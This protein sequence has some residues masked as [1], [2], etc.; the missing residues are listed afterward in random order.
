[1]SKKSKVFL[2]GWEAAKAH[3][4][5]DVCPYHP[6]DYNYREWKKGYREYLM[7]TYGKPL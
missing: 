2:Q 4:D 3:K 6:N 7:H 5:S 1:M